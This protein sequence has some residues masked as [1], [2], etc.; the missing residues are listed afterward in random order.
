MGLYNTSEVQQQPQRRPN[1]LEREK[2][3]EPFRDPFNDGDDVPF[4]DVPLDAS[5]IALSTS[6][7]LASTSLT[8]PSIHCKPSK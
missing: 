4:L 1:P 3:F 8:A 5:L 6:V 7:T 2:L